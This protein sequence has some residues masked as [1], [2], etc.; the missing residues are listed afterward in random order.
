MNEHNEYNDPNAAFNGIVNNLT[1][2]NA[3]GTNPQAG[4]KVP[5]A[6]AYTDPSPYGPPPGQ[7]GRP[8]KTGLTPRGKAGLAI[9]ATLVAGGG[10]LGYQH[11]A[12]AQAA[13]QLKAQELSIQQQKLALEQ[14]KALDKAN[15]DAAKNQTAAYQA[16]QKQINACV[17]ENRDLVGKQLG[18]TL[19]SV[20]DDCNKQYP[21]TAASTDDMQEAASTSP[22]G[23]GDG[24]T[25][26]L[27][28]GGG[29][30][31][32]GA[33]ALVRKATKP[34]P[35]PAAYPHHGHCTH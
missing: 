15:K 31:V 23:G 5:P 20:I 2:G 6:H 16:H 33:W 21:A 24:M 13:N 28:V 8:V 22:T 3:Y 27:L 34:T 29:A 25:N 30:L 17:A 9:A 26:V 10:L 4:P 18:A 35:Q 11:Y 32:I 1:S 14:Q 7:H 12:A 19:S